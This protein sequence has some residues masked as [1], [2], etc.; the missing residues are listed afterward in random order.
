MK[1]Y[2]YYDFYISIKNNNNII[3]CHIWVDVININLYF[4][5][6]TKIKFHV[7]KYKMFTGVLTIKKCHY[8]FNKKSLK[9]Y[10]FDNNDDIVYFLIKHKY[11][12]FDD[13][14]IKENFSIINISNLSQKIRQDK[15]A[16]F[17]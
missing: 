11:L 1:K 2:I 3:D 17:F 14:N 16:Q 9:Y 5:K 15:L 13:I 12:K 7:Y 6:F 10:N 8:L 4:F